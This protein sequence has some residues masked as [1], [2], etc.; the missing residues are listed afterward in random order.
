MDNMVISRGKV[1]MEGRLL[2]VRRVSAAG[3]YNS[4]PSESAG[5]WRV[6]GGATFLLFFSLVCFSL[7]L[8][9]C[10]RVAVMTKLIIFQD[11]R[12]GDGR[13]E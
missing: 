13:G 5:E 2:D 8:L 9:R 1:G 4:S 10:R 7:Q 11:E 6:G 3:S 12:Q